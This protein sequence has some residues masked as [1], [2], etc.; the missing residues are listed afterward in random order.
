MTP[1]LATPEDRDAIAALHV[2]AWEETYPGLVPPGE[3]ERRNLDQRLEIWGNILKSG[4]PVSYLPGVGFAHMGPNRVVE[5]RNDYPREL[6]SF[7]TLMHAHGTGAAQALLAHALGVEFAPFT[8]SVLKGNARATAFYEKIGG[9]R[10]GETFEEVD[11]WTMTDIVF[12]WSE[13]PILG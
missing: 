8:A 6:F 1:R 3:F 5:R 11:G 4:M 12:G 9:L 2:Q 7:Y 10:L 13:P